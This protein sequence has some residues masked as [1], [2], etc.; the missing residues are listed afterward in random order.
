MSHLLAGSFFP[1]WTWT[2]TWTWS[3]KVDLDLV[4]TVAG[5]VTSLLFFHRKLN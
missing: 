5:L 4:C 2:G 1:Y 3:L